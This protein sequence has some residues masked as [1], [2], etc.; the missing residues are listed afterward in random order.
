MGVPAFP[1]RSKRLVV[2]IRRLGVWLRSH[3]TKILAASP[4][5]GLLW[6][7]AAGVLRPAVPALAAVI[8][9]LAWVRM[10]WGGLGPHLRRPLGVALAVAWMLVGT[11]LIVFAA[12]APLLSADSPVFAGL[13]LN[14]A[15]PAIMSAP[16]FA[17]IIGVEPA[18]ATAVSVVSTAFAPFSLPAIMEALGMGSLDIPAGEL[19]ARLLLFVAVVL[20]GAWVVKRLAGEERIARHGLAIDGALVSLLGVL[21]IGIMDGV[22]AVVLTSPLKV[23]FYVFLA[24][25]VNVG[26]QVMGGLVLWWRNRPYALVLALLSGNR[27]MAMILAVIID[28]ADIDLIVFVIGC[29]IPCYILPLFMRPLYRRL[30][31]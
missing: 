26:M 19:L 4:V 14:A 11:P 13:V 9:L 10:D 3:D 2:T 1:G 18:L 28:V 22:A 31:A 6:Q 24:F 20:L 23:A 17:L 29:Q 15:A 30:L 16:A 5:V 21:V 27:N 7:D 8:I 25:A 12:V